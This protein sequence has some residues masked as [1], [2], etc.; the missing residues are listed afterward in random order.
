MRRTPGAPPSAELPPPLYPPMPLP[1][2]DATTLR[3]CDATSLRRHDASPPVA[4]ARAAAAAAAAAS[5]GLWCL[6]SGQ[7][8]RRCPRGGRSRQPADLHG[9]PAD[10]GYPR[11]PAR[12]A[13]S[14]RDARNEPTKLAI[15]MHTHHSGYL[16]Q[17]HSVLYVLVHLFWLRFSL[18][19]AFAPNGVK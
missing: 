16:C 10:G 19:L 6:F 1:R 3:S 7:T 13:S 14:R 17:Q 8:R 9:R 12:G 18:Y 4:R 15:T 11:R 5:E 2:Y